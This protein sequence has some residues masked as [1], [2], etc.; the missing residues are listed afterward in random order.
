MFVAVSQMGVPPEQSLLVVQ[1]T[2]VFVVVLHLGVGAVH[3]VMFVAVHCTQEP[4]GEHALPWGFPA[5]CESAVQ[6]EQTLAVQ[7]G[8]G[9]MHCAFVVQA[10][11][12]GPVTQAFCMLLHSACT[13]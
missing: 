7:M 10:C 8:V 4:P 3:A 6:G 13:G 1:A 11:A 5:H 9:F 2:Q 12:A